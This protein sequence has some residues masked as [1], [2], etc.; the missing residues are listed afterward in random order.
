MR[1]FQRVDAKAGLGVSKEGR[2]PLASR[3][4]FCWASHVFRRSGLEIQC[5]LRSTPPCL[6]NGIFVLWRLCSFALCIRNGHELG[7]VLVSDGGRKEEREGAGAGELS[8]ICSSTIES[9][10]ITFERDTNISKR[11]RDYLIKYCSI[12]QIQIQYHTHR[13]RSGVVYSCGM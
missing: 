6:D 4:V 7:G 9:P 11:G 5:A 1:P 12:V 10:I 2:G 8:G 3:R 13:P